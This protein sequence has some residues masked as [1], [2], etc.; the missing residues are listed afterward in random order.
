MKYF[1]L[2]LIAINLAIT[3]INIGLIRADTTSIAASLKV[4]ASAP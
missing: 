1:L 4:I 3:S 2:G